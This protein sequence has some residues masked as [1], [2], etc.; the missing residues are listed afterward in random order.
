M[1]RRIRRSIH[2]LRLAILACSLLLVPGAAAR[3]QSESFV[4]V[5]HPTNEVSA[6]SASDLRDLYLVVQRRWTGRQTVTPILPA[7][8]SDSMKVL[9]SSVLHMSSEDELSMYYMAAIFQQKISDAPQRGS[10]DAAIAAVGSD[11]G[12]IAFVPR[13]EV[14]GQTS[15]KVIEIG[16]R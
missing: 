3:A 4:A 10:S 13:S 1:T 7:S 15:V 8:D 14:E 5:V 12:A 9:L 6:L 2:A 11:P 16:E